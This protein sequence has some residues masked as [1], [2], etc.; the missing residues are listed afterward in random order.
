VKVTLV[1]YYRGFWS[2]YGLLAA[3]PF[4]PALL[5]IFTPDSSKLAYLYPPLGDVQI[6]SLAAT[7]LVLFTVTLVVFVSC[8]SARR[9]HPA[10]CPVSISGAMLAFFVLIGMYVFSVRDIAVPSVDQEVLVSIGYQ[11][12][13]FA[14]KTY[15][16]SS[17]SDMLHDQ[18]PSEE[19]IQLLWTRRSIWIMRG[20]LWLVYTLTL[21][22][23]LV[24]ICVG[25]Y[26]HVSDFAASESKLPKTQREG[27][28][29]PAAD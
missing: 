11:R 4:A 13:A 29:Q 14:L 5:R 22:C 19:T 25:V 20:I 12:T 9:I 24:V 15:P 21:S 28:K 1:Q 18:G 17:D 10:I 26:Q 27:S 7:F 2:L 8:R 6:L 3:I 23:F 16:T